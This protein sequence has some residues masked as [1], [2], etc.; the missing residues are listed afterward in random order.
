M[1]R[2]ATH[3]KSYVCSAAGRKRRPCAPLDLNSLV[4]HM[5][6]KMHKCY[7]PEVDKESCKVMAGFSKDDAYAAEHKFLG[8]PW[9]SAS[10]IILLLPKYTTWVLAQHKS[11]EGGK[12]PCSCCRFMYEVIPY[13]V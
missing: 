2:A 10:L 9:P 8:P 3:P 11:G 5:L 6:D 7:Q 12:T 4:E 1:A 13:I